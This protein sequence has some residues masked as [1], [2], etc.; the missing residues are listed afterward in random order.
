MNDP[1]L[2]TALPG[3]S[4]RNPLILAA[5]TAGYVDELAGAVDLSRVGAVVTKS[6]T[7]EPREGNPSW[8]VVETTGGML[9]AVGLANVGME[10]FEREQAPRIAGS[11]AVV[12]GSIAGSSVEEY[13][14][15]AAMFERLPAV[16]AVEL[17]VSC[18]NVHDGKQFGDDPGALGELI[19]AVRGALPTTKLIVKLPPAI[20]DI[21]ALS[22][23]AIAAGAD[24]LTIA[25]TIPAMAID[26]GSR[27]P[28]LANITGGLSGPAVHPVALR[29]VHLAYTG[30]A[31][32]AGVPII[33]VGGVTT[34]RDAAEFILAG[35]SAFEVGT[36]LFADPRAPA[37]ILA[38]LST[39]VRSQGAGSIGELVG[40]VEG[41]R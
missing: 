40:A 18:P 30:C 29:L 33:G 31:R 2:Q 10:R 36:A 6:I 39:W 14:E 41:L 17:N 4:L 22:A 23:A 3:M 20:N 38:G 34:W 26:V 35:A 19:G 28:K 5:G 1:I 9:N 32:G 16:P 11:P 7:R 24:A 37:R 21:V 12:I 13:V 25:N 27:K 15:V 8:R